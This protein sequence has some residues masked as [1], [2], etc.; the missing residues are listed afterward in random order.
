[1]AQDHDPPIS[2]TLVKVLD[3]FLEVMQADDFIEDAAAAN[4]DALLR[5]GKT[6]KP[7]DISAALFP[8][9]ADE[10]GDAEGDSA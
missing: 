8:P 3:K 5:S 1:M 6:P 9:P 2:S 10:E 4:L 7:D